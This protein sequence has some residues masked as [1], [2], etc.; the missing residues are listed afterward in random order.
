MGLEFVKENWIFCTMFIKYQ[1]IILDFLKSC[2]QHLDPF[3]AAKS[4]PL[5]P[6]QKQ[7]KIFF[8]SFKQFPP[9]S[10][11]IDKFH[12][13]STPPPIPLFSFGHL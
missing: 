9:L 2:G 7:P 11:F 10:N 1:N 12:E 8:H 6:L 5:Q 3:V 4:S 13:I